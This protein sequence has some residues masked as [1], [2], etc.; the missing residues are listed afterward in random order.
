M[1]GGKLVAIVLLFSTSA[2]AQGPQLLAIQKNIELCNR[3]DS[4]SADAQIT[5]CTALIQADGNTRRTLAVAYNNRGNAYVMKGEYD[6]AVQDFD[7]SIKADSNHSKAFNNRGVAYQKKGEYERAIA[8]FDQSIKLEPNSA[9]TY[10][11]RAETYQ[12]KGD[13]PRARPTMIRPSA[14]SQPWQSHG[15]GAAGHALLSGNCLRR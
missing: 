2:V 13:Y 11:G 4:K 6:R 9:V 10:A 3:V 14:F 1:R 15:M 5:G 8:D 12:Q 7:E